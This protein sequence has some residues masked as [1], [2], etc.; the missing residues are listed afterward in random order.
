MQSSRAKW[1]ERVEIVKAIV[2]IVAIV[3][4][5]MWA[6]YTFGLKDA[7]ALEKRIK[8]ESELAW[9]G[10]KGTETCEAE[11]K[12]NFENIGSVPIDIAKIRIRAW[13]FPSIALKRN[14][15]ARYLD[16]NSVLAHTFPFFSKEY[17][18]SNKTAS[19]LWAPLLDHYPPGTAWKQSFQFVMKRVPDTWA[20]YLVDIYE[21]GHEDKPFDSTY[22]WGPV[23]GGIL[24]EKSKDNAADL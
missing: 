9:N 4:A 1:K 13:L 21:K 16:V 14:E 11:H 7:P 19:V 12:V 10:A 15:Q 2:E 17:D 22:Q 20:L 6:Y 3:L 24:N 18:G 23:C 8:L 5:G